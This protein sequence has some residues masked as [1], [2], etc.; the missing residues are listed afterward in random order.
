MTE[1]P[2]VEP[3]AGQQIKPPASA[4]VGG[5]CTQL[6]LDAYTRTIRSYH[7]PHAAFE[8]A[9]TVYRANNP[10]VVEEVARRTVAN[11]ICWK[12]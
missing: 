1:R 2:A 9:V 3:D 11:M 10:T 12:M 8:A 7:D 4:E 5:D 6:V